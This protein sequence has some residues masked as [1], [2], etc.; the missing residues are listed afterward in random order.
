MILRLALFPH[1]PRSHIAIF[2]LLRYLSSYH[3]MLLLFMYDHT[4][5]LLFMFII[6]IFLHSFLLQLFY[7][8]SPFPISLFSSQFPSHL[9]P[10]IPFLSL[11]FL[12]LSSY[13]SHTSSGIWESLVL[14][15][16]F[17]FHACSHSPSLCICLSACFFG[18]V[19]IF[20]YPLIS[21]TNLTLLSLL[22]TSLIFLLFLYLSRYK[23]DFWVSKDHFTFW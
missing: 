17:G 6:T 11:P 23:L 16:S 15:L 5:L 21:S 2:K 12:S 20:E 7:V 18:I 8:S 9:L 3:T 19:M 1:P 14:M 4:T 22:V 10:S 13:T